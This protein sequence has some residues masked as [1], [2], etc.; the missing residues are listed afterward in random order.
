VNHHELYALYAQHAAHQLSGRLRQRQSGVE[1][2]HPDRESPQVGARSFD[3]PGGTSRSSAE[4]SLKTS[5]GSVGFRRTVG[6]LL[7]RGGS[8][9][10]SPDTLYADGWR[11]T[12]LE[13]VLWS[14]TVAVTP[15]ALELAWRLITCV[16]GLIGPAASTESIAF[17]RGPAC[18]RAA[19]T[20]RDTRSVEFS[21]TFQ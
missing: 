15:W 11:W 3:D 4:E 5:K 9:G 1:T 2:D 8:L 20:R 19:A 16:A 10:T 12:M 14:S 21:H 6:S 7:V 17:P 13:L 18:R